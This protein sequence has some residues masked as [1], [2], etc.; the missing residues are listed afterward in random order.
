MTA[1]SY[2]GNLKYIFSHKLTNK[3]IYGA[4]ILSHRLIRSLCALHCR[5]KSIGAQI[6]KF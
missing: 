5:A 6:G 3:I 4:P 1:I 2:R